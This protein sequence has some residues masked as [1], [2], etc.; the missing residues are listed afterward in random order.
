MQTIKNL[1]EDDSLTLKLTENNRAYYC[2][3]VLLV[4]TLMVVHRNSIDLKGTRKALI[5]NYKI[6]IKLKN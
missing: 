2:S 6:K 1:L 5:V 4:I 3:F